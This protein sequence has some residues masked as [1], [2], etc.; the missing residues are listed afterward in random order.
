MRHL[1]RNATHCLTI[2]A[3]AAAPRHALTVSEWADQHREL[4]GKQAGERGRWRTARTPFLRE[5]MDCFSTTSRVRKVVVK[6]S[7]QVGVTEATVNVLGYIMDHSPAPAMVLMPTLDARDAWKTQKLNP[8]L[9][10]TP[11]IH[12][13]LGGQRSRDAS[14]R[15][16][17]IDF[18]GGVLFLAGGNSPNSYA[19]R[20]ASVLIMDDLDRFPTEIGDE[21]D[22]VDLAKNR[23]KAFARS[24]LL[25]IS[26]PTDA[27]TS[28]IDR[29]Y[30]NSDR[31]RYYVPCPHCQEP[32]PL[33]WGGPE[34]EHGV[35]W[36]KNADGHVTAA[37]YQCIHCHGEI[38]EHHKPAMLAGG[39]WV[40][41]NPGHP[42]RGYHL[43]ELYAPIGL[44]AGWLELAQDWQT[45]AKNPSKLKTFLNTRLGEVWTENGDQADPTALINRLETYPEPLLRHARTAGVDVQKDR[46]EATIVDWREGEEAFTRAHIILP[47]DTARPEVWAQLDEALREWQPDAA[48]IDSGYNASM[49]YAFCERKRW[50]FAVKGQPGSSRPIVESEQIRRQRLRKQRKK[51][52]LV[53]LVGDDQAK[54]LIYAR[55]K[56]TTPGPGYLHWPAEPD[57]DDEFFAQLTAE[58]LVTKIRGTRPYSEWVQTRPRNEALDCL[59]YALAALRLS[60]I[61]LQACALIAARAAEAVQAAAPVAPRALRRPNFVNRFRT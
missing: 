52:I 43:S 18:P 15:Q 19:Q 25:L 14:N 21:G 58:K 13:L 60:G 1:P 28:L 46:L 16:D 39:H 9:T 27:D 57:F 24:R 30:E 31:R 38:Q 40:A 45:A 6:K 7:A 36:S 35:K 51:G 41:E 34:A 22:P 4:T 11:V 3:R 55:L 2:C 59:K 33:N 8:L 56:I 53:H 17:L 42:T 37:W 50:A 47:G 32:Q 20:S 12:T 48:A 61:D 26:T 5:I 23:L 29:E 44:G 10:D 49:V 54:A